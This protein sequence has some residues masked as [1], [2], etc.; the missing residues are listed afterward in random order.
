M[1]GTTTSVRSVE[2]MTPPMI[3]RPMGACCSAPSPRPS[4][5]GSMPKIIA[6]VVMRIGRSRIWPAASSAS[7]RLMPRRCPWFAKSTSNIAFLV[8]RP[9]RKTRPIIEKMLS[10]VPVKRSASITPTIESGSDAIMASGSTKLAN[11]DA[12]TM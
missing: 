11:C 6:V 3:A 7:S 8:T 1:T 12:S 10:V 2:V 9:I 4:A 5:S